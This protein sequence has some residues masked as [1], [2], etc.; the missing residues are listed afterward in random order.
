MVKP[1]RKIAL[2]FGK[3]LLVVFLILVAIL[4]GIL[5]FAE[6]S[7]EPLRLGL[8]DYLRNVSGGHPAEITTLE[9]S[10]LFPQ[11]EF[12]ARGISLRDK[13]DK[14][15]VL[16]TID[17]AHIAK[18][19]WKAFIGIADYRIF[20]IDNAVFAPGFLLPEK[21]IL[22]YAGIADPSPQSSP[23]YFVLEGR[24]NDRALLITAE[25][26][27]SG[28]KA[29]HYNFSSEFPVTFKL[30][31]T[32]ASARFRRSL[33]SIGFVQTLVSN[34]DK[35]ILLR[36]E[37][38][39]F[40]PLHIRFIGEMNAHQFSGEMRETDGD[41]TLTLIPSDN[42]PVFLADLKAFVR[43]ISDDLGF[44]NDQNHIKIDIQ[45][46]DVAQEKTNK[47]KE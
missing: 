6:T 8:Q 28:T 24:Y 37:E 31:K 21:L 35:S 4:I 20:R 30:G 22:A 2:T 46:P 17:S 12:L 5:K 11:M 41:Y 47:H 42:D 39:R 26:E 7:K 14:K 19:F 9:K 40:S 10:N 33:S 27:R 13:D 43:A 34:D 36:T 3:R 23:P 45:E 1:N 32:E 44:N 16:A 25:M 29:I 15:K 38:M 18:S